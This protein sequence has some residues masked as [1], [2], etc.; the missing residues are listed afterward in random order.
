MS[1]MTDRGFPSA[2]EGGKSTV[3]SGTNQ[4]PHGILQG[5]FVWRKGRV[6]VGV[7]RGFYCVLKGRAMA[8]PGS[9]GRIIGRLRSEPLSKSVEPFTER[10]QICRRNPDHHKCEI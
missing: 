1:V 7:A 8:T 2:T 6:K 5:S 9:T 4:K 10:G 3:P